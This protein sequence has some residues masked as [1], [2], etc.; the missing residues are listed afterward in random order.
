MVR[1]LVSES[2]D[3]GVEVSLEQK[4]ATTG[5]K[6]KGHTVPK[7]KGHNVFNRTPSSSSTNELRELDRARLV[8]RLV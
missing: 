1:R 7:P 2:G 6:P 4:G 5:P 3:F 8:Q